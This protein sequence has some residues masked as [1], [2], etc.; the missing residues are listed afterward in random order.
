MRDGIGVVGGGSNAYLVT[1]NEGDPRDPE[2]ER[3]RNLTFDPVRFPD[4]ATLQEDA[5]LGRLKVSTV[6]GDTDGDGDLDEL[7]TFG[8][9]SFSTWSTSGQLLFDSGDDFEQI[10][11]QVL[12]DFF[13][14]T[15]DEN[16]FDQRSDD[17]GPEPEGLAVGKLHGRQYAF[18]TFERIGGV[19]VYDITD[20][21]APGFQQYINNRNFAVEPKDVCG[22]KGNPGLSTCPLAGD[23]EPEG[24]LFIPSEESP[25][26]AALLAVTP[27]LSDSTTLF[28]ID[29]TD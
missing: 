26:D 3:G 14:A 15:E 11:A 2:V 23:L 16:G 21:Q 17:R 7:F 6:D 12:P 25:I 28:R 19:I 29:P 9:R 22:S 18:I 1:A 24:I 8:S 5:N 10:T 4:A 27:E 13:N 20:P